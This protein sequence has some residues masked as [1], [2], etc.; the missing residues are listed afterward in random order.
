[1]LGDILH[2]MF[3]DQAFPLLAGI[4]QTLFTEPVDPARDPGGF[5]EDIINGAVGEDILPPSGIC[6][7]CV[8]VFSRFRTIQVRQYIVAQLSR[9]KSKIFIMN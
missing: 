4:H 1:M 8:N 5:L 3:I 2:D 9:Q 7:M 6:Q